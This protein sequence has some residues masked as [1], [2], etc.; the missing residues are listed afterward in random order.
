[1]RVQSSAQLG[2]V[3]V[4]PI[5]G[6]RSKADQR[7][8]WITRCSWPQVMAVA[9]CDPSLGCCSDWLGSLSIQVLNQACQ[10]AISEVRPRI[11]WHARR[12]GRHER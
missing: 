9:L 10:G 4:V 3:T 12:R 6:L 11:Q 5:L 2:R 1:M 8:L 7:P